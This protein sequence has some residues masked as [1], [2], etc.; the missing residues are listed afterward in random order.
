[1]G[2]FRTWG[3]PLLLLVTAPIVSVALWVIMVHYEGSLVALWSAGP[4]DVLG[5]LPGPSWTALAMILVWLSA[6]ALLLVAVPGGRHLG[7]P[8]PEG[9]RP[10]YRVNGMGALALS[11]VMLIVAAGPLDLISPTIVYDHF[12]ELLVTVS[13]VALALCALLY[14]KGLHFPSTS[15]AGSTGNPIR[16]FYWGTELHPAL[17]GIQLKQ[18]FNSRFAMMG[19]S[20]II[21]SFAAKQHELTGSV[22]TGMA[23]N[24]GLQLLYILKFFHW[25]DGYYNSLDITHDRFGFYILWGVCAWLPSVYTSHSLY[26]VH[27]PIDLSLPVAVAIALVGIAALWIN[28][29]ADA[30]RQR[31]RQT[32]GETTVWGRR[33]EVIVAHYVAADG[34]RRRSLLLTSGW[35]GVARHFHYIPEILLAIAWTAPAGFNHLLPWFYVIFLTFLLADRAGRDDRRCA[36]KYGESWSAYRERVPYRMIPGLY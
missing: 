12:G 13:L 7:P 4:A 24:V 18:L 36:T 17:G 27:H 33:P 31:V 19:W 1:M 22:S 2:W 5:H 34:R 11:W 28:Y 16:D 20:V 10:V 14:V 3:M 8:S 30:Q 29:Q 23:I 9:H 32:Q 35:W 15:D 25:E 21:V 6:Q 26:L